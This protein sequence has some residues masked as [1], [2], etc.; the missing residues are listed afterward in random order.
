MDQNLK[1][2]DLTRTTLAVLFIAA[3]IVATL[4]IV[5]PFVS[6][7]L[8]ATTIVVTTWPV[9]L[10]LQAKLWGKRGLATSVMVIALLLVL[11]IPI[12]FSVGTLV[13]NMGRISAAAASLKTFSLPPPPD[14][15]GK[16][17][18][19]GA[20]LSAAWQKLASEGPDGLAAR[21]APY[22][23]KFLQWF[24]SQIGGI[25]AMILQ[26]LLTIIISAVLY[27]NGE[28]AGRGVCSFATR[29]AGPHGER[30]AI[31]AANSVRGVAMGVVVTA[32]V[33]ALIAGIGMV[34]ADIPGALLLAAA[35]LILC[36]AQIGPLPLMIP[37]IVW[38]YH[39]G[40]TLRGTVI[41]VFAL[42]ASTLDNFIRPVL[43]KKGANLPLLLIFTGVIGG[44]VSF[45]I[46]GIFVGPVILAVTYTLLGDWV[47]NRNEPEG[48]AVSDD[49]AGQTQAASTA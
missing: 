48:D 30:V 40:D 21:V 49:A 25:G 20:K 1:S 10:R 12:A 44:V 38:R 46:M 11:V 42:L 18:F 27:V 24:A 33:Q 34:A 16:I 2:R 9:L 29:L 41:L 17:P 39:T 22:A 13:S 23:G 43:I 4:W 19:E 37:V 3:L 14:W 35:T 45:G 47:A 36:L 28:T 7:F 5:F 32:A 6:A 8:W 26:F 31:L 15:I